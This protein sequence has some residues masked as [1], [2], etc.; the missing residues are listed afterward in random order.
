[1]PQSLATSVL[2]SVHARDGLKRRPSGGK[3]AKPQ[4]V[5][6]NG[7]ETMPKESHPRR[8]SDGH[9]RYSLHYDEK[10]WYMI[11]RANGKKIHLATRDPNENGC[12]PFII[13]N[14]GDGRKEL[15]DRRSDRDRIVHFWWDRPA[16][17]SF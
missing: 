15:R 8:L 1:M 2:P 17:T 13:A 9:N 11:D 12:R 6:P 3:R 16:P 10:S 4:G 14:M 5:V 7:V